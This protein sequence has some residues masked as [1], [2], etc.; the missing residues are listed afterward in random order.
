MA[1]GEVGVDRLPMTMKEFLDDA[2]V[3]AEEDLEMKVRLTEGAFELI[4]RPEL[5]K[6][7]LVGVLIK[8][9]LVDGDVSFDEVA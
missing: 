6:V 5:V 1:Q 7:V 3:L 2:N 4:S 8:L 9:A